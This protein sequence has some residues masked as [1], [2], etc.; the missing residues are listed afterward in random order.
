MPDLLSTLNESQR[1]AV[2]TCQGPVM[3][4]AGAGSGKTRVLTHRIAYLINEL[5]VY[6]SHILAV[7]FTNKAAREMKERV[8]SLVEVNTKSMWVSTFHSFC[9]RLLRMEMDYLPPF[10]TRFIIIDEDDA[11]KIIRD[12]LKN[13][14]IDS[15]EYKPKMLKSLISD[16][17]NGE[18]IKM[19]NPSTQR[20]YDLVKARYD[21]YLK[22]ENLLDFDDL[23]VYSIQLFKENPQIL[24]KYQNKFQY[25]MVD[26]FQDTNT[27]Q[28]QLIH[29]LALDHHNIF[30]VGDQD[31]SIY[32]FRGAKIENIDIFRRDFLETKLILL[33]RNYRSTTPILEAA[34]QVISKNQ[35]RIKKKLFT[36][37]ADDFKPIYYQSESSYDEVM[38][39][40][41]KIKEL[42]LA[43]YQ[44]KDFA[45]LYRANALSRGFEDALI[46]YQIPYQI[47]GA[48]SFFSRKEIKDLI[49]YLRLICN[50]DDDFSFKRIVNEPKRKIGP[51]LL[52]KLGI[53]AYEKE[54]SLFEAT[55]Y[56]NASGTGF[57]NLLDFK[58]KMIEISEQIEKTE[59][60][61]LVSLIMDKT[62]YYDMLKSEGSEGEDRLSNLDELKNVLKEADEFYEGTHKEK[63]EALLS[64]LALRTDT[65]TKSDDNNSVKLMTYHQAK[66]LEF[67]VVFMVAMEAGIFPSMNCHTKEEQEEERRICYVGITRAREK[68]YLTNALSRYL[69]GQQHSQAPSCFINEIGMDK[70]NHINKKYH[71]M[72]EDTRKTDVLARVSKI[73]E[74]LMKEATAYSLGDKINHKAFGDGLII[75]VKGDIITVAFKVPF[76]VKKLVSSHPSIRKI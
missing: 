49:A 67:K 16:E 46:R 50:F 17:K 12:I 65:D 37:N 22:H 30:V 57:N 7:T 71:Q 8:A 36:E 58:F 4:M 40:I 43:N 32:S 60:P 59:L 1:E 21:E 54:C 26:E 47:Y 51:A 19:A 55:D 63:L 14:N 11:Q 27:V 61:K 42:Y 38:F 74:P 33:E 9:A 53:V 66:G 2:V 44:Y 29:L 56:V 48:L 70:M 73:E 18:L 6:P 35:N 5:G 28:Y 39:V 10:N 52:D 76:G 41:D 31:Q 20:V 13:L 62:G 34:N 68:L 3:V 24:E 45:I 69:Y 25:I 75:D 64:D 72:F 15:K 23:I